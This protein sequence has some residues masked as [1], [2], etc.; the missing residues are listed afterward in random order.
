[1]GD[2]EVND[3]VHDI[4]RHQNNLASAERAID[5]MKA[6]LEQIRDEASLKPNGGSW[7]AGIA[8]L[9]LASYSTS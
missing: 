4:E 9:C 8:A 2:T 1:M 3:L 5:Q 7:A 6:A